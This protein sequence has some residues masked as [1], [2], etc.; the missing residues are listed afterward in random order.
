MQGAGF[1]RSLPARWF[2]P[3]F[4]AAL[5]ACGSDDEP[6][7]DDAASSSGAGAQSG[8]GAAAGSGGQSA[9]TGA[10]GAGGGTVDPEAWQAVTDTVEAAAAAAGV[11]DMGLLVVDARGQRVYERTWGAFTTGTR[12]SVA[13]SSKMIS[14]LVIF[15]VIRRGL[16]SLDS[17]TGEVLGWTG[18]HAAV[19]V[20]HLLSFTSGLPRDAQCTHLPSITLADCV[21]T[22][23]TLEPDAAPAEQ[24]D[25]G[26]THLAVAGRMAEVATGKGWNDLFAETLQVPLGLPADVEYFT[27]PRQMKG[28]TNPLLAGGMR[29][30]MDEYAS[31]L[32][33]VFHEGEVEGVTVGTPAL[34]AEQR[35]EPYPDVI[36]ASSPQQKAGYDFRYGLTA[37]LE[38][39]TPATG[40]D[41][42]SSPGAFGFT[43]W[44]DRATGYLAI[45]GMELGSTPEGAGVVTF[46]VDLERTIQPL[47]VEALA[48]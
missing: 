7:G 43:P 30:S 20:R 16:L 40:C 27:S 42:L 6:G 28:K 47:I 37:W 5:A 45:L 1:R 26:S 17:T 15:D 39:D 25:Y 48:R 46:S 8:A 22:I 33:L 11:T 38:C 12:V 35:I 9:G 4:L 34:F 10:A 3:A 19:T 24:F 29:A 41:V 31:M 32:A 2:L 14:G 23:E 21:D 44:F 13:S 18:P 36:I